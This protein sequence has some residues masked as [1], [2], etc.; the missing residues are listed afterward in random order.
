M[1]KNL[2]F[3]VHEK[4]NYSDN[5]LNNY[6]FSEIKG[7]Y[8]KVTR[9]SDKKIFLHKHFGPSEPIRKSSPMVTFSHQSLG[10]RIGK[11]FWLLGGI[12]P[13]KGTYL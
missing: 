10:V 3:L 4:Q 12:E 11:Y 6:F 8:Y 2:T 7:Q 5:G 9:R 1:L 13:G